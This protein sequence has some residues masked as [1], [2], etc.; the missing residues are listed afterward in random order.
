MQHGIFMP[1]QRLRMLPIVLIFLLFSCMENQASIRKNEQSSAEIGSPEKPT[2][3]ADTAWDEM[4]NM[5][6]GISVSKRCEGIASGKR[7]TAYVKNI[8][9][10]WSIVVKNKTGPID[11]W[12]RKNL[13]TI[14]PGQT[15]FYPFA[16]ADILYAHAFFPDSPKYILV[17]LEPVGKLHRCDTMHKD[18]F[19]NYLKKIRSAMYFSN[20]LGFFR[21]KSM[22]KD[23]NQ[24]SLD[25]TLPLIVFYLK[26]TGHRLTGIDYFRLSAEGKEVACSQ[27]STNIGVKVSVTDSL[28]NRP[29]TVYYLSY[30]LSDENLAKHPEFFVFIT[31]F[32]EQ[33]CFLKAASYLMFTQE[34]TRM[35]EFIMDNAL[36]VLQ[37]DS[38]IPY[39]Y[40]KKDKWS[41]NLFGSYTQTI[42]LFKYKFQPDLVA[43]YEKLEK[44]KPVPFRIGY[45]VVFDETNLLYAKK[46]N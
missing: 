12:R 4:A 1:S 23:L 43:A 24:E 22:E 32:G 18:E 11:K 9:S 2:L 44:K 7:W 28:G 15:L 46:K 3:Q 33:Q 6:A 17:G 21:T 45:N 14:S 29:Q 34:F 27:D 40:F 13:D 31:S 41:V 26:K 20:H 30:D 35:R 37:D 36:T 19:L 5:L 10:D 38:G 16:G 8:Q 39:R 25:G 42:E